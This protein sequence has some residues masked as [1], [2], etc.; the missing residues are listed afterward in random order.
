MLDRAGE[1]TSRR[2][3]A[4]R[5]TAPVI[6]ASDLAVPAAPVRLPDGSWL[7]AELV[8]ERRRVTPD[9]GTDGLALYNET[10]GIHGRGWH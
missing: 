10:G 1:Q 6:F 8:F 2:L 9:V 5:R 4:T 3:S 7:V